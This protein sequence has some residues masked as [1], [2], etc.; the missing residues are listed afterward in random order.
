MSVSAVAAGTALAVYYFS[1]RGA[2]DSSEPAETH[3]GVH[4]A[5]NTLLDDLYFLAEGLRCAGGAV[6]PPCHARRQP[7]CAPAARRRGTAAWL[8]LA[9]HQ[10]LHPAALPSL[11][12]TYGETLGRWRTADLLIGLAYLCRKVGG[13]PCAWH[14]LPLPPPRPHQPHPMRRAG[15]RP[16]L[17]PLQGADI[18]ACAATSAAASY[19]CCCCCTLAACPRLPAGPRGA[20]GGRHCAAGAAVWAG[21]GAGAVARGA[22][23]RLLPLLPLLLPQCP[24]QLPCDHV[25]AGC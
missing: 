2:C 4:S 24:R 15:C 14:P 21:P 25:L 17:T 3:R 18:A 10:R 16:C 20:P 8:P 11:R 12:Y 13:A 7:A 22:G 6:P 19:Q 5:P 9:A 1:R 23:G